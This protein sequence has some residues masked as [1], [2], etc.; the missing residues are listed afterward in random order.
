MKS[1]APMALACFALLG[2]CGPVIYDGPLAIRPPMSDYGPFKSPP[3]N[4][5]KVTRDVLADMSFTFAKVGRGEW[6]L[7]TRWQD[8]ASDWSRENHRHRVTFELEE[9]DGGTEMHLLVEHEVSSKPDPAHPTETYWEQED[10][11]M[12]M[13]DEIVY[14]VRNR[15]GEKANFRDSTGKQTEQLPHAK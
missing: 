9:A 2:G 11:D 14:R 13:Q 8:A 4:V 10:P 7:E 3:E 5:W 1:F 12:D 6:F 15:L